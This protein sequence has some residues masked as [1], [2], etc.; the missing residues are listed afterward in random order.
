MHD[1]SQSYTGSFIIHYAEKFV[2][3]DIPP[4]AILVMT[5]V[6]VLISAWLYLHRPGK[7]GN[8]NMSSYS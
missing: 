2:Y 5:I 7:S 8:R 4:G 6:L 3:P 1:P